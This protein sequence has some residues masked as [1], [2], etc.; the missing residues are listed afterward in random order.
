MQEVAPDQPLSAIAGVA[1]AAIVAE[2]AIQPHGLIF[3]PPGQ[4]PRTGSGKVQRGETRRRYERGDLDVL[5]TSTLADRELAVP[6]AAPRTEI[7]QTL[8]AI[9]EDVLGFTPIGVDDTFGAVGGDSLKAMQV[10]ARLRTAGIAVTAV[11]MRTSGT[12]SELAR[13][14]RPPPRMHWRMTRL[15]TQSHSLP[16]R[17]R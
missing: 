9:W 13:V 2:F 4:L 16:P 11:E 14:V 12:I 3:I 17:R 7:E 5:Y 15:S 1:R 10:L 6:Y 8:T